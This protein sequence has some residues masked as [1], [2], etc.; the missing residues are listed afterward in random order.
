MA[1]EGLEVRKFTEQSTR[2]PCDVD[3]RW[4]C[5]SVKSAR[6]G[7]VREALQRVDI[8]VGV[9]VV[10]RFRALRGA[11]TGGT[12]TIGRGQIVAFRLVIRFAALLGEFELA[13]VSG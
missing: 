12:A 13:G 7:A 6:P 9:Q 10:G 4:A 3:A 2:Q 8:A 1:R 5:P 11:G